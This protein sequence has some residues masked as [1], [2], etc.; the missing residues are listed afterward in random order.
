MSILAMNWVWTLEDL[1]PSETLVLLALADAADDDG[2]C[3]PSQAFLARKS[4]Q[5]DRNVRRILNR[6]EG[7]GL[8][9]V[10]ARSSTHGRRSNLYYLNVGFSLE[11]EQQDNLSGCEDQGV[12]KNAQALDSGGIAA[13]GH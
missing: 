6:L 13:T 5:T 9:R 2:F 7:M 10:E 12:H 8:L 4:R 11:S 3:W 1:G